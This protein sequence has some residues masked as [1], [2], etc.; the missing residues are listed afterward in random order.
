MKPHCIMNRSWPSHAFESGLMVPAEWLDDVLLNPPFLPW[1]E[2]WLN[3]RRLRGSDFLMR[4]SPRGGAA[5]KG[6]RLC[7]EDQP[8]RADISIVLRLVL[9]TQPRSQNLRVFE[10]WRL[11]VSPSTCL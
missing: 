1:S 7:P 9:R 4:W 6:A 3:P 5:T 2:F 11:S 10:S 8:Q